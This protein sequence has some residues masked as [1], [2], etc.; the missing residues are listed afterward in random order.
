[1]KTLSAAICLRCLL[2]AVAGC[3]GNEPAEVKGTMT[4]TFVTGTGEVASAWPTRDLALSVLVQQADGT[5]LSQPGFFEGEGTFRVPAV[6]SKVF[7]LTWKWAFADAWPVFIVS[8]RRSFELGALYLGR[9]DA[10]VAGEVTPL[11]LRASGL[12]P[13]KAGDSLQ[14]FSLG[15]LSG[16]DNLEDLAEPPP[17][18]GTTELDLAVDVSLFEHPGLVDA[19]RSDRAIISQQQARQSEGTWYWASSRSFV[20]PPFTQVEGAPAAIEGEFQ[21]LPERE[22]SVTWDQPSFAD[23]AGQV[24]PAALAVGQFLVFHADPAGPARSSLWDTPDYLLAYSEAPT[25]GSAVLPMKLTSGDPFPPRWRRMVEVTTEFHVPWLPE[26]FGVGISSVLPADEARGRAPV[27]PLTPPRH[28][29]VAGQ[30]ATGMVVGTGL[31]PTVEWEAPSVGKPSAYFLNVYQEDHV[32]ELQLVGVFI[33]DLTRLTIPPSVLEPAT[34]Y[35]VLLTAATGREVN[36]PN[37]ATGPRYAY[38][39]TV[40]ALI[41]P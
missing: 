24:N 14:L 6:P 31:S 25:D 5:F 15:A 4:D 9:P 23:L 39:D 40:S 38:A 33:T 41:Y 11:S 22:L 16:E 30:D 18:A 3:G 19:D 13:W 28:L 34:R 10:E 12:S 21:E 1:M 37:Q 35:L 17:A 32:G 29:R 7:Y 26:S 2:V 27:P 8:D 36:R 20:A